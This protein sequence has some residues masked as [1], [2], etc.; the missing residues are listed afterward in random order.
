[1]NII[2]VC[3]KSGSGKSTYA[4]KLSR[5]HGSLLIDV[6]KIVHELLEIERVKK[7]IVQLLGTNNFVV[8]NKIDRKALGALIF[9]DKSKLDLYNALI[10]EEIEFVMDRMLSAAAGGGIGVIID[11]A[12][13]PMSKK[14]YDMCTEKHLVKKS[15]GDRRKTVLK[16]DDIT[17]EY[18]HQRESSAINFNEKDFDKIIEFEI[19]NKGFF[20]GSFDPFTMG[21]LDIIKQASKDFDSI[22]IGIAA[23]NGKVIKGI[24]PDKR[25]RFDKDSMQ[26]AILK[27]ALE[28]KIKNIECVVYN[29]MTGDKALEMNCYTLIRGLRGDADKLYEQRIADYNKQRFGLET[30]YY[31]SPAKLKDVSSSR[32]KEL[33]RENKSIESLVPKAVHDLVT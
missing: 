20:A 10:Y 28:N 29:G 9:N 30:V 8:G 22:V 2:G 5:E 16:R 26:Q 14:Y 3:G 12:L 23:G 27:T 25:R 4:R 1:M 7:N 17:E 32:I 33:M 19:K 15:Y 6:D 11:W 18:F 31:Y 21:H 24:D 13:L